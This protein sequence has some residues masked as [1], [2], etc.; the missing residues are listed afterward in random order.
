M[1]AVAIT[2]Q[3]LSGRKFQIMAEPGE[4]VSA[5]RQRVKEHLGIHEFQ[6]VK[7]FVEGEELCYDMCPVGESGM[8]DSTVQAV[9]AANVRKAKEFIANVPLF[10]K[11][12]PTLPRP[13]RLQPFLQLAKAAPSHAPSGVPIKAPPSPDFV[14]HPLP[15]STR[16]ALLAV[17]TLEQYTSDGEDDC[18]SL[19]QRLKYRE[20]RDSRAYIF[21]VLAVTSAESYSPGLLRW[22]VDWS[23]IKDFLCVYDGEIAVLT[24]LIGN[25]APY[26]KEDAQ[27]ILCGLAS[28]HLA[29]AVRAAAVRA[30]GRAPAGAANY[31]ESL[32]QIAN[33][34]CADPDES[35][36]EAATASLKELEARE[37]AL[38]PPKASGFELT[39]PPPKPAAPHPPLTA[40]AAEPAAA[41]VHLQHE[42][43]QQ[44]SR[45]EELQRE[46][47]DL[48]R[49]LLHSK[50]DAWSADG[51]VLSRLTFHS[52]EVMSFLANSSELASCRARVEI[53][54]CAVQPDWAN[55]ALLLVP[56]TE[57][58]IIEADIQLKA[59]N[60]LMLA[61]DEQLIK[62]T[63]AL[64]AKR[65]RPGLRPEHYPHGKTEGASAGASTDAPM[66][67][68]QQEEDEEE[69]QE[70]Q[71]QKQ[72]R[73]PTQERMARIQLAWMQDV[74]IVVERTFLTFPTDKD[75]SEASNCAQSAPPEGSAG[76]GHLNPHKWRLPGPTKEI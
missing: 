73:S 65:K 60:I 58:Q 21:V 32:K 3:V 9:L 15:D 1:D 26:D 36:R 19:L 6:D 30:L 16:R 43:E 8:L 55:G 14:I 40:S 13:P 45:E 18:E 4:L 59:H 34:T 42:Q 72:Q 41:K 10:K 48:Q 75:I 2:F 70:Q 27:L 33:G 69:E 44:Q 56:V 49:A 47:Q 66:Q 51:I 31:V 17:N 76:P 22:L 29:P 68:Q 23:H 63:L 53:S 62:D 46:Q 24:E 5:V 11:P 61:S 37:Q 12:P 38:P 64:L 35:V 74:G 25:L 54:G 20:P 28:F 39:P 7:L 50:A 57:Q 52:P 71:E 67:P